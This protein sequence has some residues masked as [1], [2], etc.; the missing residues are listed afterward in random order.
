LCLVEA[1]VPKAYLTAVGLIR[2]STSGSG[3]G[4][5]V[6]SAACSGGGNDDGS[7]PG[8]GYGNF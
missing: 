6:A 8:S 5:N 4:N 2:V 7:A 3:N 1:G